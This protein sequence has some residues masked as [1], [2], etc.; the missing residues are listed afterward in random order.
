M[1]GTVPLRGRQLGGRFSPITRKSEQHIDFDLDLAKSQSKDNPVYHPVRPCPYLP[2][3]CRNFVPGLKLNT[4]PS[5]YMLRVRRDG[6]RSQ[7]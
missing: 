6:D 7:I 4:R 3:F 2:Y 5:S 1:P